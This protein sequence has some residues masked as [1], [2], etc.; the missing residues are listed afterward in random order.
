MT[1]AVTTPP[2]AAPPDDPVRAALA[3]PE[4]RNG[5]LDHARALLGRRWADRAAADA[6]QEAELRALQKCQEFHPA[7]GAV[8]AWLHGFLLNV[9]RETIRS[10]SKLPAQAPQD[11]AAWE[12]LAAA[13]GLDGTDAVVDRLTVNDCLARLSEEHREVVRLRF[14]EGLAHAEIAGRLGI[15]VA[16]A[17]VRLCRA[18]DALK[19]VACPGEEE[20]P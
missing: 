4:V 3:D 16:L 18:L 9:V 12:R 7:R 20:R 11:P 1:P 14:D 8:R 13:V 5:L 6:V 19:A 15:S 2:A 10:L 17:R